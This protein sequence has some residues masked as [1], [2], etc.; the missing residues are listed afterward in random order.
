MQE[1]TRLDIA[2]P[3]RWLMQIA[4]GWIRKARRGGGGKMC[5]WK[6]EKQKKDTR[7]INPYNNN[8]KAEEKSNWRHASGATREKTTRGAR[9][10]LW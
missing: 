2:G 1:T 6:K 10:L 3:R 5:L 7:S 8:N 9:D 4:N